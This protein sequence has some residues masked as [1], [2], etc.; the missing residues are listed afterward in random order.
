M[1]YTCMGTADGDVSSKVLKR[2]E[3]RFTRVST[4][5]PKEGTRY[6]M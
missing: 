4:P 6:V 2:G 1:D 5:S 3:R